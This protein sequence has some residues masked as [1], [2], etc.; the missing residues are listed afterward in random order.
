[1][2][3]TIYYLRKYR[4]FKNSNRSQTINTVATTNYAKVSLVGLLENRALQNFL[5]SQHDV[6]KDQLIATDA[7]SNSIVVADL[8]HMLGS[9][10]I[11]SIRSA[12]FVKREDYDYTLYTIVQS[13]AANFEYDFRANFD[14][15]YNVFR[16]FIFSKDLDLLMDYMKAVYDFTHFPLTER[17][18]RTFAKFFLIL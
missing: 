15:A 11:F 2:L 6:K 12:R 17:L 13:R 16:H 10:V 4:C 1:M 3:V 14:V 7:I 5:I 9:K 8:E 18:F